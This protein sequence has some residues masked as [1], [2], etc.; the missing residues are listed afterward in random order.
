MCYFLFPLE[1]SSWNCYWTQALQL[2]SIS[3]YV[4]LLLQRIPAEDQIRGAV[5]PGVCNQWLVPRDQLLVIWNQLHGLR[6]R[7]KISCGNMLRACSA[8]MQR[9]P[10]RGCTGGF[11]QED[12]T[13][14][15]PKVGQQSWRL[16]RSFLKLKYSFWITA[17]SVCLY[18]C[19]T[20][21]VTFSRRKRKEE[22]PTCSETW[23]TSAVSR[24]ERREN[25]KPELQS[26]T[27]SQTQS[28]PDQPCWH[29]TDSSTWNRRFHF[30]L[31][32]PRPCARTGRTQYPGKGA[33][34]AQR[35]Q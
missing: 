24:M 34:R 23:L 31:P 14:A 9:T 29:K 33:G 10:C 5:L 26:G 3:S 28:C 6:N 2:T 20:A 13:E 16:T 18:W 25:Q 30:L 19:L 7:R 22:G 4:R 35:S 15:L 21:N 27:P 12:A 1:I 11:L 17:N 8:A 32:D